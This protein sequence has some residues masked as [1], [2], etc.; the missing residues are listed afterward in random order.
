MASLGFSNSMLCMTEQGLPYLVYECVPCHAAV[1][2]S[3]SS[4]NGSS[5]VLFHPSMIRSGTL[6]SEMTQRWVQHCIAGHTCRNQ[7]ESVHLAPWTS[8]TELLLAAVP[9]FMAIACVCVC[10]CCVPIIDGSDTSACKTI[11]LEKM[12]TS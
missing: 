2:T 7:M 6:H 8:L 11:S 3:E 1:C 5:R 9:T 4:L 10:V 12:N